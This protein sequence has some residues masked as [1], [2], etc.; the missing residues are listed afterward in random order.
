MTKP[1]ER[2]LRLN[3]WEN[4][5]GSERGLQPEMKAI[6]PVVREV[7][8]KQTGDV[9]WHVQINAGQEWH[10]GHRLMSLHHSGFA[11]DFQ[12]KRLEGGGLGAVAMAIETEL[13]SRLGSAYR[14]ELEH[15]PPHLHVE[16]RAGTK[17]S[18]PGDFPS[19]ASH[20]SQSA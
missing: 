18:N 7:F 13:K 15:R 6:L 2:P 16:F 11:V 10:N 5:R 19:V 4:S 17:V 9:N 14:V 1:D 20:G 12:T 8:R 3:F